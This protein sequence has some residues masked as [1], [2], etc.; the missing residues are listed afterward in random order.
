MAGFAGTTTVKREPRPGSLCT[1][2]DD[3]MPAARWRTMDSPAAGLVDAIE[4]LENP[5]Q[6]L[7]TDAGAVVCDFDPGRAVLPG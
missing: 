6:V 4:A 1:D 7:R 5:L 3:P 2:T